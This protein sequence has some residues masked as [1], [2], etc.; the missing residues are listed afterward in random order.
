MLQ[1]KIEGVYDIIRP[2]HAAWLVFDSPHSGRA[3]P[4]DFDHKIPQDRIQIAEDSLVDDL[5]ENVPEHGAVLLRALFPRTYIDPNRDENDIKRAM[6]ADPENWPLGF[7]PSKRSE[8]GH[9]LI[10][11]T[12]YSSSEKLYKRPLL[13]ADIMQRVTNYHRPYHQA[14][15]TLLDEGLHEYGQVWH[16]NCH[17]MPSSCVVTG[18]KMDF[19][20][21]DAFGKAC[22]EDG[23]ADLVTGLL[24]DMGYKVGKNY[25]FAGHKLIT[26]YADPA[27]GIESLQI[28]INKAIYWD[29]DKDRPA[30][31]YERVKRD[32][33]SLSE[34]L[35]THTG[36]H[37]M[38][39]AAD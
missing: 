27:G 21:G 24:Q 23:L 19:C 20:L 6:V 33:T 28:E 34:Q 30:A 11:E 3:Y 18:Q 36:Q 35:V 8:R 31:D 25:P 14:L 7:N 2:S 26:D 5:F 1:D 4:E 12:L 29:E 9:G 32:L 22:H 10:R 39:M 15:R 16:V 37:L 13:A 38:P 17:A